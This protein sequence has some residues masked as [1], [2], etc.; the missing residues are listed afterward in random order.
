MPA[1]VPSVHAADLMAACGS[2][3]IVQVPAGRWDVHVLS[4]L[5]EPIASR[6]RHGGFVLGAQLA[7]NAAF[8][9]SPAEA[10]AMDPSQRLLLERG[11][12]ALHDASLSR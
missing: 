8:S 12:A 5:P 6:V 4:A 10:M 11:Y 9:V 3:A 2:S 7:D 1:G